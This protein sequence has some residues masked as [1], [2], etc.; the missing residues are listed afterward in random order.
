MAAIDKT[1][2]SNWE[3]YI[4]I[5]EWCDKNEFI[6]PNGMKIKIYPYEWTKEDFEESVRNSLDNDVPVLNTSNT[7]DYFLIKHCPITVVQNRMIGC[8]GKEYVDSV[9]N[10]TSVFDTFVRPAKISRIRLV[11]KPKFYEPS[12]YFRNNRWIQD[13]YSVSVKLPDGYEDGY[14]WY[15]EDYNQWLLPNELG[16][17]T[18][19]SAILKCKTWKALIRQIRKWHLPVG[20]K[21]RVNHFRLTGGDCEFLVTK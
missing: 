4:A 1:Y 15:N 2:I 17:L 20:S 21:I 12:R 8:Y 13:K 6:C 3:D 14:A 18:I 16:Y 19:S 11:H 5:K 9:K 10:G 7:Q